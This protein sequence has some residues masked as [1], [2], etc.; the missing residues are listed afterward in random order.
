M[1]VVPVAAWP[2]PDPLQQR[3]H[4]RQ[5]AL[6]RWNAERDHVAIEWQNAGPDSARQQD[7]EALLQ[8]IDAVREALEADMVSALRLS[9]LERRLAE[10]RRTPLVKLARHGRAFTGRK[11]DEI[12]KIIRAF[13]EEHQTATTPEVWAHLREL[14]RQ[15]G[16]PVILAVGPHGAEPAIGLDLALERLRACGQNIP[17]PPPERSLVWQRPRDAQPFIM[18]YPGLNEAIKKARR[19]RKQASRRLLPQQP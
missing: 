3:E 7:A 6:A 5:A 11:P 10:F 8:H 19:H 2:E 16:H 14:A 15:G 17:T 18:T 9:T 4:D 1:A 12:T 13:L